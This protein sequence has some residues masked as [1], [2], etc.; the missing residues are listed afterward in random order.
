MLPTDASRRCQ[1]P[2]LLVH[3]RGPRLSCLPHRRLLLRRRLRT[4]SRL[5]RSLRLPLDEVRYTGTN[6][7]KNRP[8]HMKG[9]QCLGLI[10]VCLHVET[11]G[12]K[13]LAPKL[14]SY[15]DTC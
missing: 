3:L 13:C 9:A 6:E 15:D 4:Q 5:A 1:T 7:R 8:K 11:R 12:G 10:N 14:P 2:P